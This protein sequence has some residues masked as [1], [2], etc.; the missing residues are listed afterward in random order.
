MTPERLVL[1]EFGPYTDPQ[2]IDFDPLRERQLFLIH[3]ATGSGKSTLLDAISFALY[4]KTSGSERDG[5]EMRSDFATPEEPTEVTLD[6]RLGDERY[7]VRRRPQQELA[8]KRGEGTTRKSEQATLY[9]RSE[10]E[11]PEEDGA[12]VADGKR[13]VDGTVENLLGLEHEQFRQVVVLPQGKFR[14][15]LSAGSTEREEILKVLFETERYERLQ[16]ILK[17]MASEAEEE[18]QHLREKKSDE[19]A[20]QE[21]EDVE[22]LEE[23]LE[24]TT[25]TL[26]DARET[27]ETLAERRDS[28]REALEQAQSAQ[29]L[30]DEL[31]AAQAAVETLDEERGAHE[32]RKALLDDAQRAAEVAPVH[33]DMTTRREENQAASAEAKAAQQAFVEATATLED[34]EEA[35]QE[36]HDRDE[37][38][39]ALR[40]KKTRLDTLED[41]IETLDEVETTLAE[42]RENKEEMAGAIE[43]K[44]DV[45]D[46]LREELGET[47]EALEETKA[48]AGKTELLQKEF[49][50]AET[51]KEK[52]AELSERREA[53]EEAEAALQEAQAE[54]D[55]RAESLQDATEQLRAL[56]ERRREAYAAVLAED[57]TDGTPCPVCGAEEHPA[58]AQTAHDVPGESEIEAARGAKEEAHEALD[59]ARSAASDAQS[60][61]AE[62]RA[63][64]R[65]LHENHPRLDEMTEEEIRA[66][67]QEADSALEEAKAA[68][69]AVEALT[70]EIEENEE[71]LDKL[72]NEIEE[73]EDELREVERRIG[74][75]ASKE[76][77]IRER[78]PD[79]VTT[80]SE[81][82]AAL[83]ETT[84]E[85]ASLEEALAEAEAAVQDAREVRAEKKQSVLST[86]HSAQQAAER[87]GAAQ[88]RF[89][90]ALEDNDFDSRSAFTEARRDKE[91]RASL[92]EQVDAFERDWAAATDRR[93]RAEENAEDIEEPDVEGAREAVENV[94][95]ELDDAK[96]TVTRL[97]VD[98]DAI[99]EALQTIEEIEDDL[100]EADERYSQVGFLAELARGDNESRMSL[101]RFVLATRLEEVLRVA[102]EH[103]AHMTQNRYRLLRAEEVGDK[104]SGSGLDLR[105]HDAYTGDR[106]PV[107]TLSGGEGVMAALSLALGLSDVVQSISGGRHLETI[108]I[109]EGF[110]SLD[111]EALD[112]AMEALSDL[113]D[114]GRLVGIISH[115]SELKQRVSARVEVEQTQEGSSLS[116]QT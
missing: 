55:A 38:R 57:L 10:A 67:Y 35:L 109:D 114:T 26:S 28:A 99:E 65:S 112:R 106:R 107:A 64:V 19:L 93:A 11:A 30:L 59:D 24:E 21:T 84:D 81:L 46:T 32:T 16:D 49:E 104:R 85:L 79:E 6:F 44:R 80:P 22:G 86:Q 113:R 63:Q 23:K 37:R 73:L 5:G 7:R 61:L 45:A 4:G 50:E 88:D 48:V 87:L 89:A 40:Q 14:Q 77:T 102:N 13:E 36:E 74:G 42:Q 111:P 29:S 83:A 12:P 27:Q 97:E 95:E 3:G 72:E 78:L 92:A 8:K 96:E 58:P 39:E 82:D 25:S 98:V 116:M 101:Q 69:E 70:E 100:Q 115:V 2:T 56:E 41:D 94:E 76:E 47:R 66:E 20:R 108:F 110:G 68:A 62:K 54:R 31:A 33:D 53:V 90:D 34:A 103:I 105:V 1:N 9:D 75:L 17:E 15:F 43:E 51:R 60:T 71:R 18:V 52:A 91:E